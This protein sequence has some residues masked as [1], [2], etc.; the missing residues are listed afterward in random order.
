MAHALDCWCF[1]CVVAAHAEDGAEPDEPEIT[2]EQ[3]DRLLEKLNN[4]VDEFIHNH[5]EEDGFGLPTNNK[6]A[7]AKMRQII[8][9]VL[10]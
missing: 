7:Q 3:C 2:D 5:P 8:R 4:F 6:E 9:E 1:D 10:E